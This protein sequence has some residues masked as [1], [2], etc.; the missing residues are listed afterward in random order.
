MAAGGAPSRRRNETAT[1]TQP[2]SARRR[3]SLS[4]P[5]DAEVATELRRLANES[6]IVVV[7]LG[8]WTRRTDPDAPTKVNARLTDIRDRRLAAVRT[9]GALLERAQ[10]EK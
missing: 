4:D 8:G 3:G 7:D 10:T 1:A 6:M 9:L 2:P 5:R